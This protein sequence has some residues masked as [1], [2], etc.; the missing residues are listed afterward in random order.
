MKILYI[1]GPLATGILTYLR[2][3]TNELIDGNEITIA[4]GVWPETPK[5]P[6]MLFDKR[7]KLVQVS[8]L[9]REI[10]FL[11]DISAFR[12]IKRIANQEKPDV[13]HLHSSKAGALGR[14]A[15]SPRKN[16]VYYT[17]HGFSFLMNES[18]VKKSIYHL[19][20]KML[21]GR[22]TT[23]ACS[24]SEYECA[25][26]LGKN[27]VCIEN[28]IDIPDLIKNNSDEHKLKVYT[29]GRISEQKN[30]ALFNEIATLVPNADFIWIG[31]GPLENQLT[32]PNITVTGW[33]SRDEAVKCAECCDV[34]VL[35]SKWEGLSV[36]LLEAMAA[37]KLCLVSDIPGNRNAIENGKNG[38][39]CKTAAEYAAAIKDASNMLHMAENARKTVVEKFSSAAMAQKYKNAYKGYVSA[40]VRNAI[41]GPA[42]YYRFGQYAEELR[43]EGI[44]VKI[45]NAYSRRQY[46][47]NFDISNKYL[48]KVYQ[49]LLFLVILFN[50]TKQLNHDL[51]YHPAHI[52][53]QRELFPKYL[54]RFLFSKLNRL[55]NI[56]WDFDDDIRARNECSLKEFELLK[57]KAKSIIV[58]NAFLNKLVGGKALLLPTTDGFARDLDIDGLIEERKKTFKK[59]FRTVWVGSFSSLPN[60]DLIEKEIPNLRVV[61]NLPYSGKCVNIPWS[62]QKAEEE[63]INAHLGIM[64]LKDEAYNYGKGAFKLIQYMSVGIPV[65]AS[66]IGFNKE[67]VKPEFG[68]FDDFNVSKLSSDIKLWEQM[69]RASYKEYKE[70]YSYERNLE[71]WKKLLC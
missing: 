57:E 6:E 38:I 20:E 34:F 7:V 53:I 59:E 17:P 52:V 27:C 47:N 23:I 13:I 68:F 18:T 35:P 66:S 29:S 26:K 65:I 8:S 14:A 39:I 62:R 31:A 58:T 3:L 41:E 43:A 15:F 40:Y 49:G 60:L 45:N 21:A 9:S 36:S 28:G 1:V 12:E 25:Q 4:Y 56:I 10:S 42:C 48:K 24:K 54:P 44:N 55:D 46:R 5:N 51:K 30:P 19:I 32:A 61:C 2:N 33:I 67:V 37:A 64:P 71:I 22:A 63:L 11:K 50:R 16:R 69:S 70:K